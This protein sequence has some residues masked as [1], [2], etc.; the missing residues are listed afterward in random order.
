MM[1]QEP[2]SRQDDA[3]KRSISSVEVDKPL[4]KKQKTE[5]QDSPQSQAKRPN[6]RSSSVSKLSSSARSVPADRP[7]RQ[8]ASAGHGNPFASLTSIFNHPLG[9]PTLS[10]MSADGASSIP[11]SDV[12]PPSTVPTGPGISGPDVPLPIDLGAGEPVMSKKKHRRTPRSIFDKFKSYVKRGLHMISPRRLL[13]P[14]VK[15]EVNTGA[16]AGPV[17]APVGGGD[18]TSDTHPAPAGNSQPTC[19]LC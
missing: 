5:D 10:P 16:P 11:G 19:G 4:A 12:L 18:G 17:P 9:A 8:S 15:V 6:Q 2:A 14:T 3:E 7:R 1:A 13:S